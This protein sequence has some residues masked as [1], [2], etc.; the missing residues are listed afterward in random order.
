[1]SYDYDDESGQFM[2]DSRCSE[3]YSTMSTMMADYDL[4]LTNI[5]K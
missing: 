3:R 4:K 5:S 1:M 2:S